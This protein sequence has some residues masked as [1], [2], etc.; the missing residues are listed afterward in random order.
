MKKGFTLIELLATLAILG[1]LSTIAITVSVKRINETK[2]KSRETMIK[3]IENAA[4]SYALDYGDENEN[5]RN[6]DFMYITLETLV[7]KELLTD[8]LLDQTTK[9]TLPLDTTVYVTRNNLSIINAK[10][11]INQ[12]D[13]SK[14]TL[15][16]PFN[17]YVKKDNVYEEQGV[18]AIDKNG[19]NVSSSIQTSGTV[20]TSIKGTYVITY[21]HSNTSIT[22][23]VIV[24]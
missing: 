7:S 1:I 6:N 20:N 23:N 8:N 12:K 19:N 9:K 15:N 2:E 18:T 4:K 16:G 11:D 21:T 5:F 24:Y 13:N 10:Y 22:R 17:V 3:S 14:I